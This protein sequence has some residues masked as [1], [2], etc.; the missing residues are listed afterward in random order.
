MVDFQR[1]DTHNKSPRTH[2]LYLA[3][4]LLKIL[5]ILWLTFTLAETVTTG[6]PAFA[7]EPAAPF[8]IS[9][10]PAAEQA[11][12][13]EVF[14]YTVVITNVNPKPIDKVIVT[15]G[16]PD[17]ATLI[18]GRST[19]VN[20]YGGNPFPGETILEVNWLTVEPV[21]PGEVVTFD[22]IVKVLP[23]TA[24]QELLIS[25]YHIA[26][27][28]RTPLVFGVPL[29]T[30]VLAA[31]P[32][33]T[34]LPTIIPTATSAPIPQP[35]ATEIKISLAVSPEISQS[36]LPPQNSSFSISWGNVFI[37][38][39]SSLLLLTIVAVWFVKR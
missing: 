16:I 6:F 35:T 32:T 18:E 15:V 36:N 22:L 2:N 19:N 38:G 26:V 28:N 5:A 34:T 12:A 27:G 24:N 30:Q 20:W 9:I 21:T 10:S 29:R 37:I 3:P 33:P 17:G 31:T 39:I 13:G 14:T 8:E 11:V 23:Q 25:N 1:D 7:Q 4:R